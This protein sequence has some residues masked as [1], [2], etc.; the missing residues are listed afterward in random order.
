MHC[1]LADVDARQSAIAEILQ[2][3]HR[4]GHPHPKLLGH[5][6][7]IPRRLKPPRDDRTKRDFRPAEEIATKVIVAAGKQPQGLK[8]VAIA[9][10]CGMTEVMP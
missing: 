8:P 5:E 10:G 6:K 9:T 2:R 3:L 7:Q 4:V 1:D